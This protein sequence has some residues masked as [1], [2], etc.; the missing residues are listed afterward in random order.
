VLNCCGNRVCE[1]GE[2]FLTCRED[3]GPKRL[4][5]ELLDFDET[6][7]FIHGE[8]VKFKVKVLADKELGVQSSVIA[9]GFFGQIT[10]F[11]D[12]RHEDENSND[13]IYGNSIY[14]GESV[15]EGNYEIIIE[16]EKVKTIGT[17]IFT[18]KINPALEITASVDKETYLLGDIIKIAGTIK[19]KGIPFFAP[20]SIGFV[21]NKKTI[22]NTSVDPDVNGFFELERH[23]SL[24]DPSGSWEIQFRAKDANNNNGFLQIEVLVGSEKGEAYYILEF[25]EPIKKSFNRGENVNLLVRVVDESEKIVQN[26]EVEASIANEKTFLTEVSPGNYRGKLFIPLDLLLGEQEV[27]VLASKKQENVLFSGFNS[28]I[29]FVNMSEIIIE[30]IEPQKSVFLL[31]EKIY[32]KFEITYENGLPILGANADLHINEDVIKLKEE[33]GGIYS[34]AFS[35][36]PE[37]EDG[38]EFFLVVDDKFFNTKRQILQLEVKPEVLPTYFLTSNPFLLAFIIV[39]LLFGMVILTLFGKNFIRLKYLTYKN[40]QLIQVKKKLQDD[41]FNKAS[42]GSIDYYALIEKYNQELGELETQI[43]LLKNN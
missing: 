28:T 37:T 30:T 24:I 31:G 38:F 19:K 42:I 25:I 17:K 8:E 15:L 6:T 21:L 14:V 41:Y 32:F 11:D 1:G 5:I 4:T 40:E 13:G 23:T 34:G 43:K 10:L 26:A 2:T 9:K 36:P 20:V 35:L 22:F 3:C 12:G 7:E 29:L 27:K 18:L 33:E 16:A 39:V